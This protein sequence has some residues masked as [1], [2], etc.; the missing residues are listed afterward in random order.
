MNSFGSASVGAKFLSGGGGVNGASMVEV[1]VAT[2]VGAIGGV[3]F[4][5][6]RSYFEM[7]TSV[8][9]GAVAGASGTVVSCTADGVAEGVSGGNVSTCTAETTG[10]EGVVGNEA[11]G[12][13]DA[14]DV[15]CGGNG[16]SQNGVG[17][18]TPGTPGGI[19]GL[20]MA[21]GCTQSCG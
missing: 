6:A 10:G 18:G 17:K 12:D 14:E 4:S 5:G 3:D 9:V 2:S 8:A 21:V 1:V 20:G 19:A 16:Q 15:G 13:G 7:E 11:E